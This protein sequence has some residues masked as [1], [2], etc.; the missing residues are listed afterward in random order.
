M[1]YYLEFCA[2]LSL[3]P[4]QKSV[5]KTIVFFYQLIF[6]GK[7]RVSGPDPLWIRI[8]ESLDTDPQI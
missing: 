7:F 3:S 6:S 1:D 8:L 4:F 2:S 5:P